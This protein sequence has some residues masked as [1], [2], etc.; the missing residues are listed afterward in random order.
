MRPFALGEEV[1]KRLGAP[2][3]DGSTRQA[4]RRKEGA[5]LRASP[6]GKLKVRQV[7][8]EGFGSE[9]VD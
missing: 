3:D 4:F 5:A 2:L 6:F 1:G 7:V 8:R 9:E